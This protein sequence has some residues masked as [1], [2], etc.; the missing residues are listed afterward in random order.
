[1]SSGKLIL[2]ELVEA[3]N[4]GMDE[5]VL[6]QMQHETVNFSINNP[7]TGKRLNDRYVEVRSMNGGFMD[8][9]VNAARAYYGQESDK[10]LTLLQ[11]G[12][13]KL[14][15]ITAMEFETNPYRVMTGNKEARGLVDGMKNEVRK[16]AESVNILKRFDMDKAKGLKEGLMDRVEGSAWIR[17]AYNAYEA[18]KASGK[19]EYGV[20]KRLAGAMGGPSR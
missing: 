19:Q 3:K 17:T 10:A 8:F 20:A 16:I 9:Y 15:A 7:D 4:K 6:L 11:E 2:P 1:M 18:E 5:G 13:H 14:Q 12:D